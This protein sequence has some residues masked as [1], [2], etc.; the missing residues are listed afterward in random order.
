MGVE[1]WS[2]LCD[3]DGLHNSSVASALDQ[4][5]S[6]ELRAECVWGGG[7][8]A[9]RADLGKGPA[10][11]LEAR[12]IGGSAIHF[13][14]LPEHEDGEGLVPTSLDLADALSMVLVKGPCVVLRQAVK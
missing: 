12:E 13:I 2:G 10:S 14:P 4:W 7:P 5:V 3:E 11:P 8:S 1:A 6:G 9:S